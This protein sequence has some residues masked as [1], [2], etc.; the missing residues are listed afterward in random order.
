MPPA[1]QVNTFVHVSEV[2]QSKKQLHVAA[3]AYRK[4]RSHC[5]LSSRRRVSF[6]WKEIY[7]WVTEEQGATAMCFAVPRPTLARHKATIAFTSDK[8]KAS[9][10][11]AQHAE[12]DEDAISASQLAVQLRGGSHDYLLP[13]VSESCRLVLKSSCTCHDACQTACSQIGVALIL[14]TILR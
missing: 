4:P 5:M 12:D 3:C 2:L 6:C 1:L 9:T 11:A 14:S 10:P 8:S 13:H 7:L